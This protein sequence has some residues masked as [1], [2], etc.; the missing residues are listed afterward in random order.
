MDIKKIL[1]KNYVNFRGWSTRRKIVVIES[2]DWGSIRMPSVSARRQLKEA[3]V[4]VDANKFT[5]LDTLE[6]KKDLERLFETLYKF[7]DRNGK[8]PVITANTLVANPHFEKIKRDQF[9]T[10]H[11]ETINDTYNRYHEPELFTYW[12]NEGIKEKLLYPQFHGREHLNATRWLRLLKKGNERERM[13]FKHHALLGLP[14]SNDRENWYMAAFECHNEKEK[15]EVEQM[16]ADGLKLFKRLFGF[17]SRS[18]VASQ[19]IFGYHVNA[20]LANNGVKY[21]Q[22]G[23]QFLPVNG[24]LKIRNQ[25]WG[26]TNEQGQIYWRRNCTFEPYKDQ[27][28]DHITPCLNEIKIVFRWGKPAVINSHRINY[29]GGIDENHREQS[30]KKL[31]QLIAA[32]LKKWPD[33]EFIT[34]EELGDFMAKTITRR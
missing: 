13:A 3:G 12:L 23:Q 33:V 28:A 1:A 22:C 17:H 27:S 15:K 18:F 8:C 9:S 14:E 10:Y 34:S 11:Y 30:L 24:H 32:I 16:A 21:H 26:H 19:S 6:R 20:V 2:D 25:F 31:K 7:K 4:P 5:W 29:V